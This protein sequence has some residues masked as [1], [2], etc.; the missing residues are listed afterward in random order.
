MNMDTVNAWLTVYGIKV[1]GAVVILVLGVWFSRLLTKLLRK[2]LNKRDVDP[3]LVSFCGS[4][5]YSAL[6]V[7]VVIAALNQ[8][9]FQT[10]SL[11]AVIGAA[12]L[13]IGLALQSSLSNFA[14]GVM[15]IIFKPFKAGDFIEGGGTAGVVEQILIF[16][17]QLR[18]G[19]NKTVII[20]N[21][22][23]LG[24]NIVNY[25]TKGTRR[26][27]LVIGVGYD[28]DIRKVKEVLLSIIAAE[29]RF[30]KDPVPVVAVLELADSSVNFAFRPWV[31]GNDYWPTYFDTLETI[32]LRFDEEG[33]SIPYP[34]SDVHMVPAAADMPAA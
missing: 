4:L 26:L 27:D 30:L 31:N 23:L 24:G 17:T 8:V 34:Q 10:T 25:S 19:D 3:T 9:G 29:D 21:G 33:I 18:T 14:A 7:F 13:A 5:V 22:R 6:L 16:S 28:D 12:G 1:L 11:I 15:M 32:K 20:P 2:V